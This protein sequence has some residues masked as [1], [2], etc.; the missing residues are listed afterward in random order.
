MFN[1]TNLFISGVFGIILIGSLGIDIYNHIENSRLLKVIED[2][3]KD[4]FA[5]GWFVATIVLAVCSIIIGSLFGIFVKDASPSNIEYGWIWGM[6]LNGIAVI[7]GSLAWD[8]TTRI[9]SIPDNINSY[10]DR[11]IFMFLTISYIILWFASL[12]KIPINGN[13]RQTNSHPNIVII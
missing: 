6:C 11:R 3:E 7:S 1:S 8:L 2:I 9:K 12:K 5:F 13:Y 10:H 4:M